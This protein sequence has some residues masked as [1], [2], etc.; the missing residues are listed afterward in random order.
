MK[1]QWPLDE[2]ALV[3]FEQLYKIHICVFLEGK[4]WTTNRDESLKEATIFLSIVRTLT[5]MKLQKGS[6]QEGILNKSPAVNC[7]LRSKGTEDNVPLST[8]NASSSV[9]RRTL[10]SLQAGLTKQ[11]DLNKA[12]KEYQKLNKENV[13]PSCKP[14]EPVETPHMPKPKPWKGE[15]KFKQHGIRCR[16]PRLRKIF[17][18][19]R[20]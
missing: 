3:P 15:L 12:Y 17:C 18:P 9:Q 1:P 10:N 16:K 20:R 13:E 11:S 14:K 4:Y 6:L 7:Y 19:V 8:K 2:I 5:F